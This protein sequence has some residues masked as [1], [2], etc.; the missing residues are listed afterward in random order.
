MFN[1]R[2][3]SDKNSDSDN[4]IKQ[5]KRNCFKWNINEC[6]RLQREYEL[7][8]LSVDEIAELHQRTPNSIMFR[9]SQE[10]LADYNMLY[11]ERVN[12]MANSKIINEEVV[13]TIFA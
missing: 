2:S 10:G 7:L 13:T 11:L 9:L 4:S 8:K 12:Q 1:K 6:L 3:N 5:F